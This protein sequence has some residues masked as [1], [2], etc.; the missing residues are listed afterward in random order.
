MNGD[1]GRGFGDERFGGSNDWAQ[2]S[3][4]SQ[5]GGA[6]ESQQ[7][8]ELERLR[9]ENER[10]RAG[11]QKAS[12]PQHQMTPQAQHG[13]GDPKATILIVGITMAI[14]LVGM[15]AMVVMLLVAGG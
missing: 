8:Q 1:D 6:Q 2:P 3:G 5:G 14:G 10:L 4:A 7:Q 13:A 15:V 12:P 9:A 11:Q